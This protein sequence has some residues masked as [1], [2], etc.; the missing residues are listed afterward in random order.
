MQTL[1]TPQPADPEMSSTLSTNLQA[2]PEIGSPR[3]ASVDKRGGA[4]FHTHYPGT[5]SQ[6]PGRVASLLTGES[7]GQPAPALHPG[8]RVFRAYS[9]PR[10]V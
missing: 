2:G 5:F 10:R 4:D 3:W 1:L 9:V 8:E 6:G 7:E